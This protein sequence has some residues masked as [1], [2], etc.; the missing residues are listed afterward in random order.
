MEI[1]QTKPQSICST[2]KRTSA[3]CTC[4]IQEKS[5]TTTSSHCQ[6]KASSALSLPYFENGVSHDA[7]YLVYALDMLILSPM[8]NMKSIPSRIKV[9]NPLYTN[10][11][12]CTHTQHQMKLYRHAVRTVLSSENVI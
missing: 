11:H 1:Q 2:N 10:K 7:L 5:R 3:P 8:T 4:A 12:T 6:S 9:M